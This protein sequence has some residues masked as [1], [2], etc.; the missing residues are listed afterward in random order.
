V[1]RIAVI[2][3]LLLFVRP[4]FAQTA[5]DEV[6]AFIAQ[7]YAEL[8]KGEEAH[9]YPLMAPVGAVLPTI[10]PDRC[11]PQPRVMKIKKGPPFPHLLAARAQQFAYE[12]RDARVEQTL[13]RV[14]VW[15]RGWFWAWAT[16]QTYENAALAT[17]Y[18][19][20]RDGQ[21]WKVALYRSDSS[22]VHPKHKND[23]MPDLSPKDR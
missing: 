22:A 21:G 9:I 11:G 10:C 1:F 12:I 19:E 7:W 8:R 16:Q 20:K 15:E 4:A 13:A 5:E 2:L 14:D 3:A 23:P 18:L 17:F 6:N